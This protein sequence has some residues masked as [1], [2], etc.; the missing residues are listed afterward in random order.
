MEDYVKQ[1]RLLPAALAI[2]ACGSGSDGTAGANG[3]NGDPGANANL[4]TSVNSIQPRVGLIG[5]KASVHVTFDGQ[6][7]A[8]TPAKGDVKFGDLTVT[9]VTAEGTGILVD[10]D[11]PD[12]HSLGPV[13]VTVTSGGAI[14]AKGAFIVAAP[15]DVKVG[16]GKA[17]QGGLVQLDISNRDRTQFDTQNFVLEQQGTTASTGSLVMLGASGLTATDGSIFMLGDPLV[18]TGKA[19]F[20]GTNDPQNPESATYLSAADAVAVGARD[21]EALTAGTP[22]NK[23]LDQPLQ[24][25]YFTATATPA[26]NEGFLVDAHAITPAGST[27]QPFVIGYPASGHAA[28]LLDA[29][30]DDPGFPAFGIPATEARIAFPVVGAAQKSFFVVV[31]NSFGNSATTKLT[32]DYKTYRAALVAEQAGAHDV[33][34]QSLPALNLLSDAIPGLIVQG[35]LTTANELDTYVINGLGAGTV[36]DLTVSMTADSPNIGALVDTVSTFDSN[37]AIQVQMGGKVGSGSTSGLK[38][39][40]RFLQ[41][42]GAK[43]KYKLGIRRAN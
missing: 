13:D 39:A 27:L 38:A 28:D 34:P 14:T 20:I 23:T 30:Q 6:K 1:L 19:G 8:A 11:I 37:G 18:Q 41:V 42:G 5:R 24:T 29:K 2:V 40:Q 21:P 10:L 15:L 43:G 3:T 32:F 9:K 26:A 36:I 33:T 25:A 7:L 17:E 16:G 12:S 22:V 4:A 35:E 31:D